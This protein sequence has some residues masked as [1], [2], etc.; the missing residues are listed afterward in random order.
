MTDIFRRHLLGG[1][2]AVA[3]ASALRPRRA[4][5]AGN[6]IVWW[7][8]GFYQAEDQSLKDSVAAFEKQSGIK[9]DLQIM[10]GPDLITKLIAALHVGDVPDAVQAVT[11][12]TFLLP[13]AVWNDQILEISDVVATQ[14]QAIQ[15]S[16]LDACRYYNNVTRSRGYYGVPIKAATMHEVYWMPLIEE[17]GF[18]ASE[19]PTT[20]DA[21]FD[22]FQTV[23]DRLRS[24]GKRI[25]GLGYSMATKEA[26]S[27]NLFN[28]FL[29][30]YGGAGIVTPEGRLNVEDPAV[31]K[32]AM[33]TL[34]RLTTPYKKGYVP[35]GSINW[36]DVDNNNA[37]Y[38]KQVVMTPNAT[39]SIAVAQM[40]K[41]D[42]YHKE[43]VT[44]GV[45]YGNDGKPVASILG[46]TPAVIPKAAKNVDNAKTF[47]KYFIQP[48]NLNAYLKEARGRWL[49]VM[50]SLLKS[51][52]YWQ[53]PSDPHRQ[54][55]VKH[56]L[57]LPT[58][59]PW[60]TFNP[61][62]A[63]VAAEQIWPQAEANITQRG[64]TV[65]QAT[66]DAIQRIKAIFQKFVIA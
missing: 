22:F 23:Q 28:S 14:E 31:R 27:G 13:Q 61:A 32:A 52:P 18:Q 10:T 53:D 34:D 44:T 35:P 54:A 19:V 3:A 66:D 9:V 7:T 38:A 65:E 47:L 4:K 12:A 15:Q 59:A 16:A 57:L 41:K 2:G 58:L 50:P 11:A 43:I 26:D 1:A 29:I 5:A 37:F 40:E 51:D 55:A 62:Y 45:P 63:Q 21:F 60:Q 6:L 36:G 39:I 46:V 25:F 64:M 20:Q 33:T 48:D 49:P 17:A 8:Q 42:Q 30:A 24:K 56:G